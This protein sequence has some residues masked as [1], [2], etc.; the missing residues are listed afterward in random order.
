M[1]NEVK[2]VWTPKASGN[3]LGI[4]TGQYWQSCW[5]PFP[6]L[7][8]KAGW[9]AG[10]CWWLHHAVI[11]CSPTFI[12]SD[13][14]FLGLQLV[15]WMLIAQ[16]LELAQNM[17]KTTVQAFL[18]KFGISGREGGCWQ[19]RGRAREEGASMVF[20][21]DLIFFFRFLYCCYHELSTLLY[22]I[23]VQLRIRGLSTMLFMIISMINDHIQ[24]ISYEHKMIQPYQNQI[25]YSWG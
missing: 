15:A 17:P 9:R 4:I 23:I 7:V 20:N 3:S 12:S 11:F 24:T 5:I 6:H 18:T 19:W 14:Y 21:P 16:M 2:K 13:P 10:N 8:W 25:K 1:K 22:N